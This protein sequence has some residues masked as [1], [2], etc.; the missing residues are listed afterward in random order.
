MSF[1]R[2]PNLRIFS[3]LATTL[4]CLLCAP[5]AG[6]NGHAPGGIHS[7]E[8]E[9]ERLGVKIALWEK[10]NPAE[11]KNWKQ[12]GKVILLVHGATWS[13]RCTFD[14]V[15]GYSLMDTLADQGYDVWALDLHGYGHSGKTTRDWTESASAADDV[16]AAADY[17]RALRWVEKID[18]LGY[19]WGAQA[20]G[21]FA[22]KHAKKVH[23][24]VLYG[25]RY[26]VVEKHTQPQ[27]QYRNNGMGNA[28]LKPEDGDLDV[29]FVRR[30]AQVCLQNDPQSPNGAI[31]DLSQQ[32]PVDPTQVHA[33]TLLIM[34]EKDTEPK[35]LQDRLDFYRQ[36]GSRTRFFEVIAGL[37]KYAAF[38]KNRARFETAL[39]NFLD[40][41]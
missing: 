26:N 37:G 16:D 17:I 34:G 19:D 28:M 23:R 24:L 35:T 33:P 12:N 13:S 40:M 18:V 14:P 7:H 1:S 31:S 2:T 21:M 8:Y 32:S 9:T 4:A 25:M 30:R 6:A 36:L 29:D 41:P 20:A 22:V 11:E 27:E 15:D 10:W 38:E 39:V 3:S 5:L